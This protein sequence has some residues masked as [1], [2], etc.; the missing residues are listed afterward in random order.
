MSVTN[1]KSFSFE[2]ISAGTKYIPNNMRNWFLK[3]RKNWIPRLHIRKNMFVCSSMRIL[4]TWL[5][6]S[7]WRHCQSL[8]LKERKDFFNTQSL[9]VHVFLDSKRSQKCQQ[10]HFSNLQSESNTLHIVFAL[11]NFTFACSRIA[12]LAQM[13]IFAIVMCKD[14]CKY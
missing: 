12:V 1:F 6:D 9:Q 5:I 8:L 10:K 11:K 4:Q 3:R 7:Y 2:N 14:F 13:A